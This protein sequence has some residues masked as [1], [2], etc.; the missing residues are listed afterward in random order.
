MLETLD[1]ALARQPIFDIEDRLVA[2][3]LLYRDSA[4]ARS[5]A[6]VADGAAAADSTR[7]SSDT[8]ARTLLGM[9]LGRVTGGKRAFIN[10]DRRMLLDG[11]V[12]VLDPARVVLELLESI[13][14]D[15][16]TLPACRALV[17]AGYTLAL[18]DYVHAPS[19][20]PLL[21]LATIVKVDVLGRPPDELS[22]LLATL[23][24]FDVQCLAERVETAE[25][26]ASCAELGFELFQGYFYA[27]PE[28]LAGREVPVQQANLIRLLNV[29]RDVDTSDT[30]IETIFR[31]DLT[32]TYR[33][34]RIVNSAASGRGGVDSIAH[35]IRLLGRTALHRWLGLLL[36]SS[37]ATVSEVRNELVTTAMVRAR[38]CELLADAAGREREGGAL[39]MAGL[40]S[41]LDALMRLPMADV[42][43]RLDLTP[44]LHDALLVRTGPHAGMLRLAE[45]YETGCWEE[46]LAEADRC[47][48][49]LDVLPECYAKAVEWARERAAESAG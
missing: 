44:E 46:V 31:G 49:S 22:G 25:V 32:L 24:P 10:V 21:R 18:D 30:E 42:V 7:M 12:R 48:V 14:C 36:V 38:F 6:D 13:S 27:R 8:I 33:L 16:E 3:E 40:F 35:A 26:H 45:A 29:L 20:E 47:G 37:F 39:F 9:G 41:L 43:A 19:Y 11:S 23:K 2:Y 34:L 5:A 17:D 4:R 28:T 15:E 1:I